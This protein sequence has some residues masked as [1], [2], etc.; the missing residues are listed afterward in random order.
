MPKNALFSETVKASDRHYFMDVRSASNGSQYVTIT[1]SKKNKE[2]NEF[3]NN[4]I[5]VF[6]RDLPQFK[7]ALDR[8][9]ANMQPSQAETAKSETE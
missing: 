8:L 4:R 6:P 3:E 1:E 7:E 2:S 9:V 5:L